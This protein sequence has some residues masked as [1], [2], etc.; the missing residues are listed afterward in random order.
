MQPSG[1]QTEVIPL[2]H[3]TADPGSGLKAETLVG[4]KK[5]PLRDRQ[6][7]AECVCGVE[8]KGVS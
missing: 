2:L 7:R 4:S 1:V 8:I 5:H 3:P 6:H